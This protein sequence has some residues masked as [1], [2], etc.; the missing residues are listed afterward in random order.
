MFRGDG[1]RPYLE[2]DPV[3]PV[4]AYGRTKAEGEDLGAKGLPTEFHT[5]YGMALRRAHG[6]NF[7][8]TMLKLMREKDPISVV[9]DQHGTPTWAFD[10][11]QA[12]LAVI[13]SDPE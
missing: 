7:V 5:A 3:D 11:A 1:T 13:R 6:P 2:T 8:R 10:L 4:G 12:I 9:A